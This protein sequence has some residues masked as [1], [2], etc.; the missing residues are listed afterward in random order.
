[1]VVNK[2][3]QN[4][5]HFL[6]CHFKS[7]SRRGNT[8]YPVFKETES[9]KATWILSP[10]SWEGKLNLMSN[11]SGYGTVITTDILSYHCLQ[12]YLQTGGMFP[13]CSRSLG[14]MWQFQNLV[15]VPNSCISIS[16]R[17]RQTVTQRASCV[18]FL[19]RNS[20][21]ANIVEAVSSTQ[22]VQKF[23]VNIM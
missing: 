6:R 1:M 23:K 9:L 10:L 7:L 18:V 8:D 3:F 22:N 14:P 4:L 20:Y 21:W 19:G 12:L 16:E 5:E 2:W 17:L 11:R 13:I 15:L